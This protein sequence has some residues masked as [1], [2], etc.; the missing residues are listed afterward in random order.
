M[1]FG[2]YYYCHLNSNREI[3]DNFAGQFSYHIAPCKDLPIQVD[4]W[5]NGEPHPVGECM[6]AMGDW[7]TPGSDRVL[8]SGGWISSP[9][10]PS[11]A[12]LTAFIAE[13]TRKR[14]LPFAVLQIDN[15]EK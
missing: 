13:R 9:C 11:R 1:D 8:K 5:S 6:A 12:D 3:A 10:E 15:I 14:N 2:N 4:G 7:P